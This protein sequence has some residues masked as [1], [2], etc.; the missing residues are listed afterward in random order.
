MRKIVSLVYIILFLFT[1]NGIK[2]QI[3]VTKK[4]VNNKENTLRFA[5]VSDRTGGMTSDILRNRL[6]K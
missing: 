1:A 3:P 6:K 2:A 5:I 4:E